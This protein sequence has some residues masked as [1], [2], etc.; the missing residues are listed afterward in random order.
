MWKVVL[1]IAMMF[2]LGAMAG[3]EVEKMSS[4]EDISKPYLG[5][6]EAEELRLGDADLTDKFSYVRLELDYGGKFTLSYRTEE[7]IEEQKTGRYEFDTTKNEL[8]MSVNEGGVSY[9]RT[10]RVENGAIVID[11]NFMGKQL[12]AKFT[13]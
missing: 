1:I 2:S 5:V 3:C 7:G 9:S 11:E 10:Y 8:T 12:Y 4:L 13:L 6:Y